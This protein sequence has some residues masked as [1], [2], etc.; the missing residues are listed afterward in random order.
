MNWLTFEIKHSPGFRFNVIDFIFIVAS[1]ILSFLIYNET[2][3]L[4]LYLIP[5]YLVFSFFLFC[6]VFRIGNKLEV[7]WYIPFTLIAI[8]SIYNFNLN[9]FWFGIMIILEPIKLILI[10]YKIK[11]GPYYGIFSGE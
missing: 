4:S 9:L 5:L 11:N 8:V 7:F 1:G 10:L 6:N 3:N 2:P